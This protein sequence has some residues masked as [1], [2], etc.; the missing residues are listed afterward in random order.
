[1]L[2]EPV[3]GGA[4]W[5]GIGEHLTEYVDYLYSQGLAPGTVRMY[6]SMLRKA[7]EWAAEQNVDLIEPRAS[8]LA[9][10]R[11]TFVESASTLRQVRCALQHWWDMH[12]IAHAPVKALRVPPK[13]R[14]HWRGLPDDVARQLAL[15]SVGWHPE[16]TVTLI[17][18]YTGLRRA[19]I[20]S[21]RWDRFSHDFTTY[22]VTGKGGVTDD[23]PIHP[24]L[25]SILRPLRSGYVWVFPGERRLHVAPATIWQ[26]IRVVAD[27]CGVHVTPHQLRHTIISRMAKEAAAQGKDLRV[28][29]RFARHARI[30]TTQTYLEGAS[31]EEVS[32]IL[33]HVDW[34]GPTGIAESA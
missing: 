5:E 4:R 11:D 9:A 16:G 17:G 6:R 20:A 14:A 33:E 12:G 8:E 15:A 31:F 22:T 3:G 10:L 21:M 13:P 23:V 25:Q 2:P 27:E 29:Q 18:L 24:R 28:A 34:L 30:D 1:M 26:W 7:L 19:E 32:A